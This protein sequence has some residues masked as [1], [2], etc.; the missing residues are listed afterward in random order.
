M[1]CVFASSNSSKQLKHHKIHYKNCELKSF[2][3]PWHPCEF[4]DTD[5]QQPRHKPYVNRKPKIFDD[6]KNMA[7]T[8]H[9]NLG[10]FTPRLLEPK[11][12]QDDQMLFLFTFVDVRV[13]TAGG[14]VVESLFFCVAT[15]G[16]NPAMRSLRSK[17]RCDFGWPS[18][19]VVSWRF[20]LGSQWAEIVAKSL[21]EDLGMCFIL[22]FFVKFQM[23]E[24]SSGVKPPPF[25][26]CWPARGFRRVTGAWCGSQALELLTLYKQLEEVLSKPSF[27]VGSVGEAYR[28]NLGRF[29]NSG[30]VFFLFGEY[31]GGIC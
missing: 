26:K 31:G 30:S 20:A 25:S 11:M 22:S 2:W 27:R 12:I 7:K 4:W 10:D 6:E 21:A 29:K 5:E 3:P 1:N 9:Q 16:N 23:L 15:W 8:N 13:F 18:F 14:R 28:Q 19:Y 17:S 24:D